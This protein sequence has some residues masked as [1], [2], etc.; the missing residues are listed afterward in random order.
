VRKREEIP[1][2]GNLTAMIDVVFQIIIFFVCT[3][4]MQDMSN[5]PAI[6][7]AM[8]PNGR[9]VDKKDPLEITVEVNDKGRIAIA[10]TPLSTSTLASIMKKAVREWGGDR[11]PVVIRADAKA[12]HTMVRA[13]MDTCAESGISK[14]KIAAMKEE[15]G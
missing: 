12:T 3:S 10:R 5:D 8:A 11:V 13:A 9:A 6:K 4:K 1:L 2:F 7:L 15:G 14:I